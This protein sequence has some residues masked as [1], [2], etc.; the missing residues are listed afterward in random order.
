MKIEIHW[1][2]RYFYTALNG[3]RYLKI[4]GKKKKNTQQCFL[5]HYEEI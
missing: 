5:D 3:I 4:L 1:E 2:K